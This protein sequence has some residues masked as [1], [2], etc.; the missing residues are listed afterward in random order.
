MFHISKK[1]ILYSIL[2]LMICQPIIPI[3]KTGTYSSVS[4]DTPPSSI[5]VENILEDP[6]LDSEPEVVI[7]GD[8]GEFSYVYHKADDENDFNHMN[9]TWEHSSGNELD[10]RTG[11]NEA[12]PDYWDFIY[13]YQEFEWQDNE[14]P[15]DATL[16]L[17]YNINSTGSFVLENGG[18]NTFRCY[19]WLIDSSENWIML[20]ESFP[21]YIEEYQQKEYYLNYFQIRDAWG[22]TIE[23]SSGEQE[24]PSDTVR[25]A[26][27]LAPEYY[28][29]YPF[30]DF[31]GSVTL[32]IREMKL[33]TYMKTEPTESDI[34]D[35][36][37]NTTWH[38]PPENVFPD[39]SNEYNESLMDFRDLTIAD[40]GFVYVLCQAR[41]TFDLY[42]TGRSYSYQILMKYSP[43]LELVW[44]SRNAN[45]TYGFDIITY[46]GFIYT[47]GN[48]WNPSHS[49]KDLLFTKWSLE[50]EKVWETQWGTFHDELGMSI[51]VSEDGGFYVLGGQYN[52]T[53][54]PM[55]DRS[56]FLK[57]DSSGSVEW[58]NTNEFPAR[59]GNYEIFMVSD[60]IFWGPSY[61]MKLDFNCEQVWNISTFHYKYWV[62]NAGDLYTIRT[63]TAP[64]TNIEELN[65]TKWESNDEIE[66]SSNYSLIYKDGR[67]DNIEGLD[68]TVNS[69]GDVY[70]LVLGR[71]L[72]WDNHLLKYN[73]DGTLMSDKLVC[74][75]VDEAMLWQTTKMM[76]KENGVLYIGYTELCSKGIKLEAYVADQ[77]L[78]DQGWIILVII[79]IIG[80]VS[81]AL[82]LIIYQTKI[83]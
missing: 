4:T 36:I 54:E 43:E 52:H 29:T 21:P 49:S 82:L 8:S 45:L 40:D 69:A 37:Y 70:V 32:S 51:G 3:D 11:G 81:V 68:I 10:F 7:E 58:N 1:I 55:L 59:G 22:G 60:G 23:D 33:F 61:I 31:N 53:L 75:E 20:Y 46:D 66:W 19:V 13:F 78:F 77:E 62:D 47:T 73:Q 74:P 6:S 16:H 34:L 18:Q 12:M 67:S 15:L 5:F 65:V 30:D 35:P 44:T 63:S 57:F 39:I 71:S 48:K 24:D 83:R 50:G 26:V 25:F 42:S 28:E 14:L 72:S 41:N 80:I 76:L 27:G 9:L 17:N 79:A 2:T 38:Y 56:V 64:D